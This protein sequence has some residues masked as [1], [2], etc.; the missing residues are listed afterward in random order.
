MIYIKSNKYIQL[1]LENIE[2]STQDE[3]L[4]CQKIYLSFDCDQ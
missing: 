2:E 4:R 3:I 1:N